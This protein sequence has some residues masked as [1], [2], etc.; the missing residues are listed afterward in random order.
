M[1]ATISPSSCS[2]EAA[3]RSLG[4]GSRGVGSGGAGRVAAMGLACSGWCMAV[5]GVR[6]T[7]ESVR[8]GGTNQIGTGRRSQT[9]RV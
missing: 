8:V 7:G 4:A 9:K 6:V 5:V 3:G 1:S 2:C